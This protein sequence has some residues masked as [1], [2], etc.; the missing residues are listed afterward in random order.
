MLKEVFHE[1]HR[2]LESGQTM[3][4]SNFQIIKLI[5]DDTI[6]D[7]KLFLFWILYQKELKIFICDHLSNISFSSHGHIIG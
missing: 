1:I 3:G 4:Q 5:D 7:L 2:D 6:N